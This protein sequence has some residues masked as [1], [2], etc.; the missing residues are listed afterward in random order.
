MDTSPE[1]IKMWLASGLKVEPD[2]YQPLVCPV[3]YSIGGRYNRPICWEHYKTM[4]P[5]PRQDQLQ[6][7]VWQN[8]ADSFSKVTHAEIV[9]EYWH[10]LIAPFVEILGICKPYEPNKS[11]LEWYEDYGLDRSA[12]QLWLA[13][14]MHELHS[15]VWDGEKWRKEGGTN[16]DST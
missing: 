14:V 3:C 5:L 11:L 4:V 15:K 10:F 1:Y 7:I 9:E 8:Y 13:F 2:D 6:E 16:N 12:E